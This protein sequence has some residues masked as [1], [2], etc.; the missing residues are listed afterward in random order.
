[1]R[2][3]KHRSQASNTT[4]RCTLRL[5][6]ETIRALTSQDLKAAL[7]GQCDAATY[8]TKEQNDGCGG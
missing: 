6:Q 8:R 1:M 7:A 3:N 4:L 5:S 2:K